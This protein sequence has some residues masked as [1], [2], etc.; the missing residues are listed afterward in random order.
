MSVGIHHYDS[1]LEQAV[2]DAYQKQIPIVAAAGNSSSGAFFPGTFDAT[3]LSVGGSTPSGSRFAKTNIWSTLDL[4]APARDILAAGTIAQSAQL[5]YQMV[6]GTSFAAAITTGVLALAIGYS[7][8][9]GRPFTVAQLGEHVRSTT[10][11]PNREP[12]EVEQHMHW[13]DPTRTIF[14]DVKRVERW[15]YG[16]GLLNADRF[17]HSVR[18]G[19]P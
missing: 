4:L 7:K 15:M 3:V 8:K 14:S 6:D 10:Q 9:R 11:P 19:S 17:M 1:S 5:R 13:Y 18:E 12:Q 2:Q 16:S